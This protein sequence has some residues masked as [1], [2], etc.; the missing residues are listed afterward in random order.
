MK[1]V[2]QNNYL[3]MAFSNTKLFDDCL[4]PHND[5]PIFSLEFKFLYKQVHA[6]FLALLL[7]ILISINLLLTLITEDYSAFVKHNTL[8]RLYALVHMFHLPSMLLFLSHQPCTF[9]SMLF[10]KALSLFKIILDS[11]VLINSSSIL[12]LL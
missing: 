11:S 4:C 5:V 2:F 10:S 3:N 1:I 12:Y 7:S 8:S 9:A 6:I